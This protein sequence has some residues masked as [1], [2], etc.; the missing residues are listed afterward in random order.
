MVT[1]VQDK[2]QGATVLYRQ[3]LLHYRLVRE[4]VTVVVTIG[5]ALLFSYLIVQGRF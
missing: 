2:A 4:S 5:I 1:A 3:Y